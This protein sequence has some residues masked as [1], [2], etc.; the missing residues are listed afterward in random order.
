MGDSMFNLSDIYYANEWPPGW[1][2]Y[3]EERPPARRSTFSLA[4]HT[5]D[6]IFFKI[7]EE[8]KFT[9]GVHLS[10]P[11]QTSEINPPFI[12]RR[13]ANIL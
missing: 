6:G 12:R 7:D 5:I 8:S 2:I 10:F 9:A 11:L 1:T 13:C 3:G 4:V